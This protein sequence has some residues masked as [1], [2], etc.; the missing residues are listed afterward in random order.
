MAYNGPC[1][2]KLLVFIVTGHKGSTWMNQA[3]LL[4]LSNID[5]TL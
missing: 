1:K 4:E 5:P 3:Q 2:L